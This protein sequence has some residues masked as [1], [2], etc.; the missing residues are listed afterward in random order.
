[1]NRRIL[2]TMALSVSLLWPALVLAAGVQALFGIESPTAGPFPS[3]LF[4]SADLAITR[5]CGSTCLSPT[6]THIPRTVT[7]FTSS[8]PSMALICSPVSL[9]PSADPSM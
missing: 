4:T 8:T 3:D 9:S 7:I 5:G 1:M 6:A 2:I